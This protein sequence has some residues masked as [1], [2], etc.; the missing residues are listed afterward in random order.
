MV[1]ETKDASK[2]CVSR[3]LINRGATK[4]E[5]GD[6]KGAIADFS[7]VVE[8]K[9]A[10]TEGI[11]RALIN[12]SGLKFQ[13]ENIRGAFDDCCAVIKLD[14][15][16]KE[17]YLKAFCCRGLCHFLMGNS[18][19]A[20]ADWSAVID[21]SHE[22]NELL[23]EAAQ[24]AF[25][26]LWISRDQT[27]ALGILEKLSTCLNM[28]AKGS[29][30]EVALRVL[31]S[32]ASPEV[33]DA[34]PIAWRKLITNLKPEIAEAIKFLEPVCNV[35]EGKDRTLLDALPPEQREFALE[36]LAK[37]DPKPEPNQ[38]R[39]QKKGYSKRARSKK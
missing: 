28:L 19:K 14:G 20:I 34:W 36:V 2:E 26:T 29:A 38:A 4:N 13:L 24:L 23:S 6:M 31:S 10:P 3:A 30:R 25:G 9:D 37:F 18:K 7:S 11:A 27:S 35:L 33:K 17:Q 22:A 21:Q 39:P 32:L 5:L 8:L 12:R 1:V 16:P 15:A